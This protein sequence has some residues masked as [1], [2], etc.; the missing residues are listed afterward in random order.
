V[1]GPRLYVGDD[2]YSSDGH[3]DG[4]T[5]G[6]RRGGISGGRDDDDDDDDHGDSNY[7]DYD[8]EEEERAHEMRWNSSN[9]APLRGH[10]PFGEGAPEPLD[11]G[12][13][14]AEMKGDDGFERDEPEEESDAT[15]SSE[16]LSE[17]DEGDADSIS[18]RLRAQGIV[19]VLIDDGFVS[20]ALI[21]PTLPSVSFEN[22]AQLLSSFFSIFVIH[23]LFFS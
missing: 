9:S 20:Q 10:P 13:E 21:S 17:A 23:F 2:E 1:L 5:L 4:H 12:V 3:D 6:G 16:T 19:F 15:S 7:Q 11:H 14:T 8:S 18:V 22:F